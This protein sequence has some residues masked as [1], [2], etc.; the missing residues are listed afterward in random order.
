MF[1]V[2]ATHAVVKDARN[3]IDFVV[4]RPDKYSAPANV[5]WNDA[6]LGPRPDAE[7]EAEA[8]R[9]AAEWPENVNPLS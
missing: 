2:A 8:R 1:I 3:G 7:I 9:L 6:L 5:Y 4:A